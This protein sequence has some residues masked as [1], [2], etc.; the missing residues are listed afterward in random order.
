MT[1]EETQSAV[2]AALRGLLPPEPAEGSPAEERDE[3]DDE[4]EDEE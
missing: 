3:D 1:L 2:R 4:D